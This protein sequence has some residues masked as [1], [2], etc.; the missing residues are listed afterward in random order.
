M[1]EIQDISRQLEATFRHVLRE[2]NIEADDQ[3]KEGVFRSS[4]ICYV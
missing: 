1:E 3:A 4:I 2:A